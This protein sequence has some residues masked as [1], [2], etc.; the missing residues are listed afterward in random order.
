MG[1]LDGGWGGVNIHIMSQD[2][3]DKNNCTLNYELK[4]IHTIFNWQLLSTNVVEH[5]QNAFYLLVYDQR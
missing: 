4:A 5:Y 2:F 3:L 1:G